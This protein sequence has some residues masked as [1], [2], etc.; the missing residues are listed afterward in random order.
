MLKLE[1]SFRIQS[2]PSDA[3]NSCQNQTIQMKPSKMRFYL[4]FLLTLLCM[5]NALIWSSF[6]GIASACIKVF[7]WKIH[8]F[9]WLSAFDPLILFLTLPFTVILLEKLNFRVLVVLMAIFMTIS[10]LIRC[11]PIEKTHRI[12]LIIVGQLI[13]AFCGPFSLICPAIFSTNWFPSNERTTATAFVCLGSFWGVAASF[14]FGFTVV[15]DDSLSKTF[16][17]TVQTTNYNELLTT[18]YHI[19]VYLYGQLGL[20]LLLL[21]LVAI[22][23]PKSPSVPPTKSASIQR[24]PFFQSVKKLKYNKPYWLL[25]IIFSFSMGILVSWTISLALNL[26][27]IGI[28]QTES[29]MIGF[30]SIIIGSVVGFICARITDRLTGHLKHT[31]IVFNFITFLPMIWISLT[32]YQIVP[33]YKIAIMILCGL[34][35]VNMNCMFPL[36]YEMII[37]STFPM[38]EGV[39]TG[40]SVGFEN[41]LIFATVMLIGAPGVDLHSLNWVVTV[42]LAFSTIGLFFFQEKSLR[43]NVDNQPY[44]CCNKSCISTNE[45]QIILL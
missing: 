38:S 33:T 30:Y 5:H 37:E 23:F 7:G 3:L 21:L 31:L 36:Y 40:V 6:S 32:I 9:S 39:T 29:G 42:V 16:E 14:L 2:L 25:V 1:E 11:I 35:N 45:A 24:Q 27:K 12:W 26:F 8:H 10:C 41:F 34:V 19:N 22:Y 13:N 43:R 28:T 44:V 4:L 15:P 20:S 17:G 18:E